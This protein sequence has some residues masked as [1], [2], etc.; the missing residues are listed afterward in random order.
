M[1]ALPERTLEHPQSAGRLERVVR[2]AQHGSVA[3][4]SQAQASR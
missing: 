2:A 1:T 3:G 4:L